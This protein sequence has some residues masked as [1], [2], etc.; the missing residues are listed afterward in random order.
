[1]RSVVP[2]VEGDGEVPALPILLRRLNDW[3]TPATYI[4]VKRPIRVKRDR[5]L[6]KDEEFRR[7]LELASL[8]CSDD[9]WILILLDADD[10][11][12]MNLGAQ[13]QER[14]QG[15]VP[16]RSVSVVL[17]NREYEAWFIAAAHSLQGQRGFSCNDELVAEPE[18]IRGAKEWLSHRIPNG[19]YREIVDQPAFS[20][21][22]D[23]QMALDRSRSFQKLCSDWR[24]HSNC[25][26]N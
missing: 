11:C 1:M 6:N 2:I 5:F 16:H 19:K 9:G 25:S 13:I 8:Q 21:I 7:M 24:R 22:L 14:A 4:N 3:L 23:L 20:A 17:A 10:D 26:E 12:P 15:V 18:R